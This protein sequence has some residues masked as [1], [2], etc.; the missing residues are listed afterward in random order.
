MKAQTATEWR[1]KGAAACLLAAPLLM[2]AGDALRYWAGAHHSWLVMSKLA[3]ALF[4]GAALAVVHLVSERADR[5]GLAGGAL[6]IVGC[7]AGS[8]ILT[9]NAVLGS[10]ET[11]GLEE[12]AMRAV[13]AAFRRDGVGGYIIFYP[14]PG[15]AFPLGFLVLS[16]ALLRAR[17]VSPAAAGALALGA[18]LF[19][20]G[21]IGRVEWAVLG[22]G[23]GMSLGMALIALRVLG[24]RAGEW[25]R[26][27]ELDETP[28]ALGSQASAG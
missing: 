1:R 4:V 24:M 11:S 5:A 7:L 19:P 23:L 3:F 22:S 25:G 9:A 8:G 2:L 17:V 13:E 27:R 16:Y 21:R 26:L 15:L 6:A 12:P 28:A 14:L 20:V 18:L 10:V